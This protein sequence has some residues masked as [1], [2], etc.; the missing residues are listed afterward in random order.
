MVAN[1]IIFKFRYKR[2]SI[3]RPVKQ[4]GRQSSALES[5]R[6]K[7]DAMPLF[8]N[9]SSK[10]NIFSLLGFIEFLCYFTLKRISFPEQK[11]FPERK[12]R[13]SRSG[14][15]E[16]VITQ[17]LR[18]KPERQSDCFMYLRYHRQKRNIGFP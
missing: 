13:I 3:I 17:C 15:T 14:R 16:P 10:K 1:R 4:C 5:R 8:C 11:K 9:I 2:E 7:P 12:L 6:L 18:T